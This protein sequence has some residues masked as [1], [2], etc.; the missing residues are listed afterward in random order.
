MAARAQIEKRRPHP[1][2]VQSAMDDLKHAL[3][4]P[5]GCKAYLVDSTIYEHIFNCDYL[6]YIKLTQY[7]GVV[8]ML[9]FTI[10]LK[11]N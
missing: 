8:V 7:F 2:R 6:S 9:T 5:R 3:V 11:G 1:G 4:A 10:L